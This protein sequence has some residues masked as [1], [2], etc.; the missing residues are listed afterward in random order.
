MPPLGG[1]VGHVQGQ[2]GG[3]TQVG[4]LRKQ[5]QAAPQ[6]AGVDRH[7]HKIGVVGR[8]RIVEHVGNYP[9][10]EA[11]GV[12]RVGAGQVHNFGAA[13]AAELGHASFAVHGDPR[14]IADL[15]VQAR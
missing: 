7:D 2:N 6:V 3:Q 8:G 13:G 11:L 10:V 4:E 1:H 14:K 12:E 15:L 5:Q 9:L